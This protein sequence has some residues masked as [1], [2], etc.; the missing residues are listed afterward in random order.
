MKNKIITPAAWLSQ[1]KLDHISALAV[2][3]AMQN[4]AEHYHEE[5]S[6]PK[7]ESKPMEREQDSGNCNWDYLRST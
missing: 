5:K 1:N 4:Y 7:K 3:E 6:K 2:N